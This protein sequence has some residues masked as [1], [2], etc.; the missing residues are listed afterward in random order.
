MENTTL[1]ATAPLT[2]RQAREI[3]RRTGVRPV[4]GIVP[5]V[6]TKDTGEIARYEMDALVSVLPTELVNRIAAPM[7][8]EAV[9]VPAAFDARGL[10]VRAD[11]PPVLIA[12]RRRRV[13]G[14]FAAA[15][16]VTAIAAA[17]LTTVGGQGASVAAEEH[18]ANLL[19][20]T[21]DDTASQPAETAAEEA[22]AEVV[23]P[24]P[25]EVDAQST[26]IQSFD[27]S[28]VQAAATEVVVETPVEEEVAPSDSGAADAS[29]ESSSSES[30]SSS[31]SSSSATTASYSAPTSAVGA[32][33]AETA[34]NYIGTGIYQ[35]GGN[36]PAGWDCSGFTQW[37]FAQHGISLPH[38][39]GGQS[40]LGTVVS[41]PQPGDLVIF[42][43]YHVGIYVGNGQMVDSPDVGRSIE[44]GGLD[45]GSSY[46]FVR[47]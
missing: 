5:S 24:A 15:A 21:A 14:G 45:A 33:V 32:N 16:S 44:I 12:Q 7:A 38:S 17:A 41:D 2:R 26:T 34:Q 31:E 3:E 6:E 28:V 8:D 22:P 18:Q 9:A 1:T 13:A 47:I 25:I 20:A 37:V 43:G 4:A 19:S 10:S 40:S 29:S 42:G 23:T 27:A 11:R 36:T 46:Y 39:V 35:F 30:N